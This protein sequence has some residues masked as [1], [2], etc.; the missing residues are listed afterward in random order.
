MLNCRILINF[1]VFIDELI[2]SQ[3]RAEWLLHVRMMFSRSRVESW[4]AE[5]SLRWIIFIFAH[6]LRRHSINETFEL[7][8]MT[9]LKL[10]VCHLSRFERCHSKSSKYVF[11]KRV[12]IISFFIYFWFLFYDVLK[13]EFISNLCTWRSMTTSMQIEFMRW[14][15]DWVI[16]S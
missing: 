2:Y 14:V 5:S 10:R 16:T 7:T 3:I 4:Y 8:A 11:I 6:N 1:E 13:C 15:L 9:F 12:F